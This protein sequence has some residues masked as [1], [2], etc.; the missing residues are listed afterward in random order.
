[1]LLSNPYIESVFRFQSPITPFFFIH[2]SPK[3]MCQSG[4]FPS[5]TQLNAGDE[6]AGAPGTQPRAHH[7]KHRHL[8]RLTRY[9]KRS[10][11]TQEES[12][13]L[14][15]YKKHSGVSRYELGDRI[16]DL[17]T[18]FA[19][20]F[21]LGKRPEELFPG[22]HAQAQAEVGERARQ[23]TQEISEDRSARGTYKLGRLARLATGV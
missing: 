9:R 22:L 11:F 16:P 14:L 7:M 5:L 23:L 3:S 15:G 10:G 8:T 18:V 4:T 20:Q 12:A 2:S 13:F 17:K 21:L 19:Y 1:M 6:N